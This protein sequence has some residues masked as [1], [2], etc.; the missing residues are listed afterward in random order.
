MPTQ[1]HHASNGNRPEHQRLGQM[2]RHRNIIS[3][4]QLE[5]ALNYQATHSVR[6]GE[7]LVRLGSIDQKTLNRSLR[8]QSWL[9]PYAACALA[10]G[11]FSTAWADEKKSEFINDWVEINQWL[12]VE[13]ETINKDSQ[14]L[15]ILTLVAAFGWQLYEGEQKAG[16]VS[17]SFKQPESDGLTLQLS[18]RF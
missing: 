10:L 12:H 2:L 13:S 4:E 17:F 9:T 16:E 11:S 8:R 5:Q 6:L 14:T 1:Q 3:A 7:A 18:M 15:D